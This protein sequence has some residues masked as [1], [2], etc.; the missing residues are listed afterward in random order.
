VSAEDAAALRALAERWMTE[1][2]QRGDAG[3]VARLHAPGFVDRSPAG[4]STDSAAY[5]RSIEEL[6]A[7][8]PDFRA[9]TEDLVVDAPRGRVAIRWT[10]TGTHSGRPF[11][12]QAPSGRRI[13]FTGIEIL[14]IAGGRVI[15]RW[16]EWDGLDLLAQLRAD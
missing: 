9:E 12:G 10:A 13:R 5:A 6:F 11:L 1:L 7:A 15:A 3:A 8:F 4:R 16:G 14:E 2:W